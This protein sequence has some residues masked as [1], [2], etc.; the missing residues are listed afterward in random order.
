MDYPIARIQVQMW[1]NQNPKHDK[2]QIA[3]MWDT[4]NSPNNVC[5]QIYPN[6]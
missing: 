5:P 4:P 2:L 1:I 3:Y 6:V